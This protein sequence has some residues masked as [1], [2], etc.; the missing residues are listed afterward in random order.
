MCKRELRVTASLSP[1]KR[2]RGGGQGEN[3]PQRQLSKNPSKSET[4]RWP[5]T[6]LNLCHYPIERYLLGSFDCV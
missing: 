1:S 6:Q 3:D 2:G 4:I 5:L